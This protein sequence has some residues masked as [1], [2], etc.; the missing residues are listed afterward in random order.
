MQAITGAFRGDGLMARGLRSASYVVFGYGTSQALRLA[1]NLI[2]T[3]LLFPEAFGMMA[4]ISVVLVGL[5]LFS[6]V[7]IGPAIAQNERGDDPDFLNTAWS[8]QVV[9][10]FGLWAL[11][12]ALAVPVARF[13]D[14]PELALYL[15]LA[16][17]SL[18]ISGFNPTRIHT[19]QRHLLL[20]RLTVLE[21][22]S[23]LLSLV[24]VVVLALIIKSVLALVIGGV[25]SAAFMLALAHFN[26]PGHKNR[27]RWERA[28]AEELIRFGKWIFLSTAFSFVSSQG[29]RA[30]LGRFLTLEALGFYNIGYFLASFPTILGHTMTHKILIPVYR[31][32]CH[33]ATGSGQR[34]LRMMRFGLSAI[35]LSMLAIMA[36]FG[37][38]LV[39]FL[40]D[41]RYMLAMPMVTLIAC[42]QIPS[43]IGMSYE[44]AALA[45]GDSR[46]YFLLSATRAVLQV[47]LLVAGVSLFGLTG[48]IS[49]MGLALL[50][51]YPVLIWLSRRHRV[52]DPLHDLLFF[53]LGAGLTALALILHWNLIS[54][55]ASAL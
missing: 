31:D 44:Q 47:S 30:I 18:A 9:R 51:A 15:P 23:Q 38:A 39:E 26:L 46:S 19:A 37:P 32:L 40:Y 50:L 5:A 49:A 20:G 11:T 14:A 22:S 34:K 1:S 10:G 2:L 8:I 33:D 43:I 41:D 16:G 7:G 25:V 52:W 35:L 42:A 29:D 27:F 4:L 28:A 54:A 36:L 55:M 21:L 48:A 45:A 24:V 3:R 12:G 53:T 17:I 13:Y 6:D